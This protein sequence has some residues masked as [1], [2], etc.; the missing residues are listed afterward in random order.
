MSRIWIGE[1]E[2][3]QKVEMIVRV[4]RADV[5]HK[6]N[7]APYLVL[8]FADRTHKIAAIR[9]K[10]S[11]HECETLP[12]IKFAH[13]I[14]E[15]QEYNEAQQLVLSSPL[16]DMGLPDDLSDFL[17]CSPLAL[18]ELQSRLH[19]H[20]ASVRDHRLNALLHSI[21]V[22]DKKI[23]SAFAEHPA[24]LENH[25]AYRHGLLHHTLEV[26]DMVAAMADQQQQWGG[27]PVCR[28][29]AVTG[30]LL[31]D[32]GKTEEMQEQDFTYEFSAAGSLLGHITLGAVYVARKVAKLRRE[33]IFP[34]ELEQ[35]LL[36]LIS[37]HHGKGEW[38]SPKAPMTAEAILIH[39]ADKT[40]TDLYF[41]Q[42]AREQAIHGKAFVKQRK[43]ESGFGGVGRFVFVGDVS[44]LEFVDNK[45]TAEVHSHAFPIPREFRL[46]ILR[47]INTDEAKNTGIFTRSLPLVGKIAA[48]QPILHSDSFE[49]HAHVEASALGSGKGDCY[50]LR[51]RGDSMIGDGIMDDDLIVVRHQEHADFGDLI[52][53][54]LD[55]EGATVKRLT[56]EKGKVFLL[57]SNPAHQPIPVSDLACLKIQGRV[58]GIA[59]H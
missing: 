35:M 39:M 49:G 21:F 9:W 7:G 32:I 8:T 31:H 40:S 27:Y 4:V 13:V 43:L 1:L 5:Q 25:H 51:V 56:L 19:Y 6:K 53:A 26:V 42:E 44:A 57:P 22:E 24:A 18:S 59:R 52:V 41:V 28:D 47:L 34:E 23:S 37:S 45:S 2:V 14:G 12:K 38:G 36:H 17:A 50:L 54:L 15:V 33:M 10:P 29:L 58:I 16:T 48:G 11:S 30:A 20:I 55:D 46:P 3:G